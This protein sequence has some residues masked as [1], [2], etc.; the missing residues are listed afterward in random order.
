MWKRSRKGPRGSR[1]SRE[2]AKASSGRYGM[3][4][5]WAL[6]GAETLGAEAEELQ[7]RAGEEPAPLLEGELGH[8]LDHLPRAGLAEGER[9]VAPQRDAPRTQKV[10]DLAEGGLV[11]GKGV[12]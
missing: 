6:R 12:D 1:S 2:R 7:G 4:D 11:V 8:G 9:V 10:D 5:C 3:A